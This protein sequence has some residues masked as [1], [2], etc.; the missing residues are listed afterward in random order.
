MKSMFLIVVAFSLFSTSLFANEWKEDGVL[1]QINAGQGSAFIQGPEE[2]LLQV[3]RYIAANESSIMKDDPRN[4]NIVVLFDGQAVEALIQPT[5]TLL[6]YIQKL[7]S[8][9]VKFA[10]DNDALRLSG[11]VLPAGLID[12]PKISQVE[13]LYA[14]LSEKNWYLVWAE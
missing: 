1:F 7:K 10:V 8:V 9:G 2:V 14:Q 6:R 3:A 11:E 12:A 5:P 13:K 4:Q